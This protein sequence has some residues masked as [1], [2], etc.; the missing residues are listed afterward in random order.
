[1]KIRT[2]RLPGFGTR[3]APFHLSEPGN[4]CRISLS[5]ILVPID[6]SAES[7]RA[8][9]YAGAFASYFGACL[10]L[11]HVVDPI[12]CEADYGYG[13]IIRQVPNHASLKKAKRRLENLRAKLLGRT[14]KV[15]V[16]VRTGISESEIV[17]TARKCEID[18]IIMGTH[19]SAV[20][21]QTPTRS[22]AENVIRHAPCP[23][24]VVRKT[25]RQFVSFR[26]LKPKFL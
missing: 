12:V 24:F 2:N 25:E 18:L 16:L 8:L 14:L 21:S 15:E 11:L 6:F 13:L 4:S 17:K 22:T 1:M 23:V 9:E 7:R 10:T 20:P 3:H 5:R 19:S 26:K